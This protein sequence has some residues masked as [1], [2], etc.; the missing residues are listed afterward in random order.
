MTQTKKKALLLGAAGLLL[1]ATVAYASTVSMEYDTD[2]AGSD[3]TGFE[4]TTADPE[5]C[6][7][8]CA[9]DTRCLAYTYVKPGIQG[10]NARCWL[11][12]VVPSAT[13]NSCCISGV[14]EQPQP[15]PSTLT[16]E[17]GMNRYGS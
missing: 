5:Q 15:D 12:D 11:K 3:Y 14:K 8:A 2:R 16:M 17:P 4:I 1:G 13:V 7:M 9:N 10:A 6:R